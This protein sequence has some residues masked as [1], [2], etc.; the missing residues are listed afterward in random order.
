M[1]V[2]LIHIVACV[3]TWWSGAVDDVKLLGK[4]NLKVQRVSRKKKKTEINLLM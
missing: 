1:T 3:C 4:R 2:V